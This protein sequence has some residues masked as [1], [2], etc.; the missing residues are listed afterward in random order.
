[1][2]A[3]LLRYGVH[4]YFSKINAN[5]NSNTLLTKSPILQ[6]ISKGLVVLTRPS[7]STL[8]QKCK[9]SL[10]GIRCYQD[11]KDKSSTAN[12]KQ[13]AI[14]CLREDVVNDAIKGIKTGIKNGARSGSIFALFAHP[15]Q[16]PVKYSHCV[17][18][19]PEVW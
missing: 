17:H 14:K 7:E 8:S 15:G 16:K 6:A 10:K 11:S 1:V 9:R 3:G 12:L 5:F 18:T 19:N 4:S 2:G 13:H